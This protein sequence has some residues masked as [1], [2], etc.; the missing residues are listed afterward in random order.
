MNDP[1]AAS[2]LKKRRLGI[3]N[4]RL[5]KVTCAACSQTER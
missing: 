1:E 2:N 4:E 3:L 5:G